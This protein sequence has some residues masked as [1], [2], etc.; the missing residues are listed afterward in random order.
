MELLTL[1][2]EDTRTRDTAE[3]VFASLAPNT[4]R[5][6]QAQLTRLARWHGPR[7]PSDASLADYLLTRFEDGVAPGT[8][9]LALSAMAWL[10]RTAGAPSPVGSRTRAVMKLLAARG[11]HRGRGQARPLHYMDAT[12]MLVLACD[13]DA[14]IVALLF[15]GGMRR[16]EVAALTW[17][18]IEETEDGGLLINVRTSKANPAGL[19]RDV[20]YLKDGFAQAVRNIRTRECDLLAPVFGCSPE[21]I[22][23]RLKR[24]ARTAGISGLSAHSGRVGLASEL[25]SRGASTTEVMLAGAWKSA[26]MVAHYSAGAKAQRGAVKKYF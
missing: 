10:A 26:R 15:M 4:R 11:R 14:A 5:A 16:S 25:T 19:H 17:G 6:Y 23:N 1:V 20:R 9:R 13:V 22:N 2:D 12:R 3:L 21:T 18:D 24:A 8:L 7:R